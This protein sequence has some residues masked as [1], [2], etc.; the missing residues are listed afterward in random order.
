LAIHVVE[1]HAHDTTSGRNAAR[2][3]ASIRSSPSITRR[4]SW[5]TAKM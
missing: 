2:P 1:I 4:E 3:I 5:V